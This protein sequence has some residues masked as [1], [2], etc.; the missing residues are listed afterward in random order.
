MT[1]ITSGKYYIQLNEGKLTLGIKKLRDTEW[2][3]IDLSL[4]T[5]NLLNINVMNVEFALL[6]YFLFP[7]YKTTTTTKSHKIKCIIVRK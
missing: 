6:L 7:A 3:M 5:Y 4:Y 2:V 1:D